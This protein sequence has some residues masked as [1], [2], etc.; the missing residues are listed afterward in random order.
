[1]AHDDDFVNLIRLVRAGDEPASAE[2]VRRYGP[3]IR[4]AARARLTD[5][6]LRRLVDSMDVCQSVLGNFFARVA[7]GQFTLDRPE[8]LLSLLATMVRNRVINHVAMQQAA[9]RDQRRSVVPSEDHEE[10]VDPE[11]DPSTA[12]DRR[13]LL[14]AV[15]D[16]LTPEELQ[17][18]ERWAEGEG[19]VEIGAKI[20]G[21]PDAVRIRLSR[22]LER[23]R[24]EMSPC[25]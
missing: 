6:R 17:I 25:D 10:F 21:R 3:A 13:D 5:P 14:D 23:V 1:M 4:I 19:W 16:R 8:Q 24:R 15:C 7:S 11:P 12:V 9:C 18:A 22:A 2:L 20:G